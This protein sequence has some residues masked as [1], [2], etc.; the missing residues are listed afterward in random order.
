M[1]D[2]ELH[3]LCLSPNKIWVIKLRRMG[4]GG[5]GTCDTCG[6]KREAYRVLVGK[7]E[8]LSPAGEMVYVWVNTKMVLKETG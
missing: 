1:F 4:E 5:C 3:D 2:D 7:L 6:E 8:V